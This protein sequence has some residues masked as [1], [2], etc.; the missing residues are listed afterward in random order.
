[1]KRLLLV[2]VVVAGAAACNKPSEEDCRRAVLHM[3][4]LLGTDVAAKNADNEAEV[5]RCKGGSSKKAV[6]CA[7]QATSVAELKACDFMGKKSGN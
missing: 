6:A 3:E 1:M 5:R 4:K 2:L 7:I